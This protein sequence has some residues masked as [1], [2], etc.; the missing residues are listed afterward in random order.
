MESNM[1]KRFR[2]TTAAALPILALSVSIAFWQHD[3]DWP[4]QQQ[5]SVVASAPGDI[6]WP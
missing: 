3:I 4:A 2:A 5:T 1:F 6:D